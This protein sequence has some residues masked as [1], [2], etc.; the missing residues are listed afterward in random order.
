MMPLVEF[1][2][3][4]F[5]LV[6]DLY[7]SLCSSLIR[8]YGFAPNLSDGEAITMELMAEWQDIHRDKGIHR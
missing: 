1:I 6:D 8:R 7:M 3:K 4:V 2:A 5:C